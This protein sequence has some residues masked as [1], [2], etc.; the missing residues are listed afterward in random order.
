MTTPTDPRGR[1]GTFI[2]PQGLYEQNKGCRFSG[3]SVVTA[4][5]SSLASGPSSSWCTKSARSALPMAP[6]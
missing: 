1:A 3:A 2:A 6:G 4:R 5:S